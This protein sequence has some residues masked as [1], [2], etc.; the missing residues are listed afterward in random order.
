MA[1]PIDGI[2]SPSSEHPASEPARSTVARRPPTRPPYGR[3]GSAH[4][5]GCCAMRAC[6]CLFLLRFPV[7]REPGVRRGRR[8]PAARDGGVRRGRGDLGGRGTGLLRTA[9]CQR[10]A[11]SEHLRGVRGHRTPPLLQRH[12]Q[13]RREEDRRV[14][15]DDHADELHQRQVLQRAD[16]EHPDRDHHQCR[17]TGRTP[18]RVVLID[19]IRVWLIARF[20]CSA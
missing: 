14:G 20:A 19:R 1:Y 13:R 11:A 10:R 4:R 9:L 18:M 8:R 16:A 6:Q 2:C 15:A 12:Q 5:A 17:C 3:V 7:G